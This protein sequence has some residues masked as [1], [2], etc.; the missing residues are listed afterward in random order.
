MRSTTV[1]DAGATITTVWPMAGEVESFLR[2]VAWASGPGA[3]VPYPRADPA[4]ASRLPGDT[5]GTA[6]LPVGVRL[7]LVGD[8]SAIDVGYVTLTDQLGYRGPGAGTTFSVW[9]NG[10]Q[11][12]EQPAS[13]G[14]GTVRL[15]LA[16]GDQRAIVYLPE[17]MRPTVVSLT[18]IGGAIEPAPAQ[19]R[20]LAYG[21]S[22]AEGWIASG[23]AGAWPAIAGRAQGFDTVNLGYAGS[24][25]GEIVSAEQIASLPS[26]AVISITHGTNCWT[27]IPYSAAMMAATTEAFVRIVRAG[28]PAVPIVLA[29]PVV[30]PDAET[31]P[32][33]LG[34]TL[35]DLRAAMESAAGT[36]IDDGDDLLTLVPGAEV[37]D[38][39]L[40]ADGVHPGDEGHRVLAAA[41]GGAVA[42]AH[43]AAT[44][45]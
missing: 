29:S 43:A 3:E 35:A 36:L 10:A 21:D 13:L 39:A 24:A 11:V 12:D 28:H 33:K 27:R 1:P 45:I 14:S 32:N 40:L 41:F 9:R 18:A 5:W 44:A 16:G 6:I 31:T 4:D 23:P 25:R 26:P 17:G 20:W 15:E 37:L 22:I 30:R 42:A 2:G 19:P 38:P 7:E 34:A 8:A